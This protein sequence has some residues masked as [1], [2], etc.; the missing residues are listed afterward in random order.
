MLSRTKINY[1]KGLIYNRNINR[2]IN[3]SLNQIKIQIL[4]QSWLRIKERDER[5]SNALILIENITPKI[6]VITATTE[7]GNP[8]WLTLVDI[9]I[10]LITPEECARIVI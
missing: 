8:R 2:S 9:H 3:Q 4:N 1:V 6:C 7:K 10:S 5:F